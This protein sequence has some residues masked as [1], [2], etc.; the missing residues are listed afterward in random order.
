MRIMQ[1][2]MT[3]TIVN[4]AEEWSRFFALLHRPSVR[5]S[6]RYMV[7]AAAMF[8]GGFAEVAVL[9]SG[10]ISS[11]IPISGDRFHCGASYSIL[12]R[13]T[14]TADFGSAP[15]TWPAERS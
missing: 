5:A 13:H 6:Y 10:P 8:E 15:K 4:S 9:S 14:T 7:A 3:L 2:L 12:S 1:G 11:F